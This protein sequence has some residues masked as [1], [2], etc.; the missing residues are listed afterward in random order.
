M[1]N[2]QQRALRRNSSH[3]GGCRRLSNAFVAL[4]AHIENCK[5]FTSTVTVRG[6]YREFL[7]VGA[8]SASAARCRRGA[9]LVI[10]DE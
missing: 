6:A 3:I 9:A 1:R 8:I 2:R 7:G 4:V 5:Y 10:A